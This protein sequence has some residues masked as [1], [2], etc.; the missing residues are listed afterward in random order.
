MPSRSFSTIVVR[1]CRGGVLQRVVAVAG[2]G[3]LDRLWLRALERDD[4]DR[5]GDMNAE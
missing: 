1:V 2:R 4:G 5:L 3:P